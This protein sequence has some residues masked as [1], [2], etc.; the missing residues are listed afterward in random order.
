M[1]TV[2]GFVALPLAI[3]FGS[4]GYNVE[5]AVR[6]PRQPEDA[7][8]TWQQRTSRLSHDAAQGALVD[9]SNEEQQQQQTS[10][11][12]QQQSQQTRRTRL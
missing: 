8:P 10:P 9:K 4:I 7:V 5:G 2:V 3:V 12:L 11:Q 1:P 6:A